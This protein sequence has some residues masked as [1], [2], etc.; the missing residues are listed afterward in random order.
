MTRLSSLVQPRRADR[1]SRT[2][3]R[4]L[5]AG[6]M[7][8][9]VATV[10]TV[11][12]HAAG[13]PLPLRV[14][15][16]FPPLN[17]EFLTGR[18]VTLPSAGQDRVALILVGF[19]YAS[20]HPVGAWGD[21]FREAVGTPPGVTFFEVPM[22][23]GLAKLGRWFIDSGMRKGT[24]KALHEHVI[25]VYS[26]TG[27]WK[28]RLGHSQANEDD[29]FLIVLDRDGIVRWLHHGPFEPTR[30]GELASMLAS[31]EVEPDDSIE[32]LEG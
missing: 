32:S 13:D 16:P 9:T 24:P 15:D 14:G 10:A 25:T 23:G 4:P 30:A 20:R 11:A 12:A 19:T 5:A 18:S 7:V 17:G 6:L 1:R 8:A 27:D 21:W 22:I 28:K 3:L 29:A 31:L 2:V 26:K